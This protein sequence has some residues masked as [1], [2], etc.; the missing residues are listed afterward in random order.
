[1]T[2]TAV[3]L[4]ALSALL[5]AGWNLLSKH[6]VPSAAFFFVA[7][8][9]A[10]CCLLPVLLVYREVVAALPG[11]VWVLLGFTSFCQAVYFAALAGAYRN[12]QISIAYPLARSSPVI[13]VTAVALLLGRGDQVGW[14]AVAGIVL[15]V[16]GGFLLPMAHF[17]DFR[18]SNYANWSCLF[19]LM[20]AFGTAGYSLIDDEALRM[21]RSIPGLLEG[22]A[23]RTIVFATL[24]L[25]GTALCLAAFT[26]SNARSRA[27][28]AD[29]IGRTRGLATVAGIAS[30]VCYGMVLI[31]MAHVTN[32]SYVVGFRQLSIPIGALLGIAVLKERG[33][34][35][36]YVGIAVV[37]TGLVLIAFG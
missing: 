25:A 6:S 1:M 16:A 20:A 35:P 24:E 21:V 26:F 22:N 3:V 4:I 30:A 23:E 17:S 2:V 5:H 14:L 11:A 27:A 12:G 33:C 13:V 37:F 8:L 32:V 31:S 9:A 15:V 36:K 19:A 34:G 7:T 18:F 28:F 10:T 29:V